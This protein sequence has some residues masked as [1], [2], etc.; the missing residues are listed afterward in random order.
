M[1]KRRKIIMWTCIVDIGLCC[2]FGLL[3]SVVRH[4]GANVID[5][6]VGLCLM[7]LHNH[8]IAKVILNSINYVEISQSQIVFRS[9]YGKSYNCLKTDVQR[10]SNLTFGKG[11]KV[12]T[13]KKSFRIDY[14]QDD[15]TIIVDGVTRTELL[16]GD[17]PFSVYDV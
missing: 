12:K 2:M 8:I 1:K 6:C 3:I 10:V 15:I 9:I 14:T 7:V 17:F 13:K 5:A 4:N 16:P 11:Y